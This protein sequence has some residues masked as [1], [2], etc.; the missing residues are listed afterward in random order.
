MAEYDP[1]AHDEADRK[2]TLA[3][4]HARSRR[5][6]GRDH[7][8]EAELYVEGESIA[9]YGVTLSQLNQ[10]ELCVLLDHLDEVA[11]ERSR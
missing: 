7:R 8:D 9:R 3:A 11:Y 6:F 10:R 1:L 4:V 5:L 2:R